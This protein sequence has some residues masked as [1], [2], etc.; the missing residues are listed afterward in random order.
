VAPP[1][2]SGQVTFQQVAGREGAFQGSLGLDTDALEID[3]RHYFSYGVAGRPSLLVVDDAPRGRDRDAFFLERAFDLREASLYAFTVG[4][5]DRLTRSGLRSHRAVFLA[6]LPSLS[7]SQLDAVKGYVE[8]GGSVVVSFGPRTDLNAFSGALAELGVGS[9]RERV[10]ARSVQSA[11]AI[12]GEVDQR[13]PVFEVFSASGMGAI[14]R[15]AF[16]QYV[17]V[18]PDTAATVVARYDTGDPFLIERRLGTGKVLAYTSTFNTNW[19]DF[20]INEIYLPFL[21]ELV[22]YAV[23]SN[24]RRQAF[25]VGEVVAWDARAGEEWEIQAPGDRLF[26]VTVDDFGKAFFRETEVPGNYVAAR[27]RDQYFFSVNVDPRESLLETRDQDESYAAIVGPDE[28]VAKTPEQAALMIVED[29][30]K[31]QKLWRYLLLLV[32]GLFTLETYLAN[33]RPEI[34]RPKHIHVKR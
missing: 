32:L 33:R 15:P 27:G 20:P 1:V 18:E 5:R 2:P 24:E 12:I 23:Q 13:H 25:T 4:A 14:L 8:E 19:T 29:E 11:D 28:D 31:Q 9:I 17:Q 34:G 10:T 7:A 3:N 26:K 21:Y 16:R 6:N 30:E 22:K